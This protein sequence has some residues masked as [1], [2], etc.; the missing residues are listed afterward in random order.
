MDWKFDEITAPIAR[1]QV[2]GKLPLKKAY[3]FLSAAEYDAYASFIG[4]ARNVL[5]LASGLGRVSVYLNS[6]S[7]F[8]RHYILADSD[9][10]H[11]RK[12]QYGWNS[13]GEFYNSFRAARRFCEANGLPFVN[14]FDVMNQDWKL[15]NRWPDVIISML[16]VGFHIP[17]E[18][19]IRTLHAIARPDTKIIFGAA[20]RADFPNW[21][22]EHDFSR[23]FARRDIV[24][25]HSEYP[26]HEGR[27]VVLSEKV[28]RVNR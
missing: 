1:R 12:L 16:G 18:E 15:L 14:T 8:L 13:E 23:W 4:S 17:M 26:T 7:T 20:C 2:T 22:A 11:N 28:E 24:E 19:Y 21:E 10:D 9:G 6:R 27:I 3:N 5:D 25:F